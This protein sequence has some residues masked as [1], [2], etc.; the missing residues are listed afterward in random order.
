MWINTNVCHA[1]T[2]APTVEGSK[3]HWRLDL[4]SCNAWVF[5]DD[6]AARAIRDALTVA[7]GEGIKPIAITEVMP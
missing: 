7:L 5:L 1:V 2:T 3:D 6:E 4:G